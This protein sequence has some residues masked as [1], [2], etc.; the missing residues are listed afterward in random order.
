MIISGCGTAVT[1]TRTGSTY[2]VKSSYNSNADANYH[3]ILGKVY[4]FDGKYDDAER[5]F[6]EAVRLNPFVT[7]IRV[8]LAVILLKTGKI[9]EAK[10]ALRQVA[11]TEEYAPQLHAILGKIYYA[12]KEYDNAV[13]E[14]EKSIQEN[15]DDADV[16]LDLGTVYA[17]INEYVKARETLESLLKVIPDFFLA[18]YY[19]AKIEIAR[20]NLDEGIKYYN[21]SLQNNPDFLGAWLELGEL[22]EK[23]DM[24]NEAITA[25]NKALDLMPQNINI[26]EKIGYLYTKNDNAKAAIK[27]FKEALSIDSTNLDLHLKLG[28]IYFS[29]K[30]YARAIDEFNYILVSI[31]DSPVALYYLGMTYIEKG[32]YSKGRAELLKMPSDTKLYTDSIIWV[33]FS[34]QKENNLKDA[35]DYLKSKISDGVKSV[36]LYKVTASYLTDAKLFDEAIEFANQGLKDFH[37]SETLYFQLGIIYDE[38]GKP[39]IAEEKMQKVIDINPDNPLALNYIGYTWAEK[40]INIDKAEQMIKKALGLRPNDGFIVDSLGWIY[41][42]KGRYKDAMKELQRALKL[43]GDDPIIFEHIGDTYFKLGKPEKAVELYTHALTMKMKDKDFV[44]IKD[45][46]GILKKNAH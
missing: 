23:T 35:I 18:Y 3:F 22:Y 2:P 1:A 10:E 44:R 36:E 28:I 11:D 26:H 39:D 40:A 8:E 24:I 20:N 30:D 27:Y 31:P 45:K 33:A 12:S 4:Y 15:P 6:R 19:I 42:Q 41:Y 7:D 13:K 9:A 25:Y 17:E 16:Y 5:E 21:L 14:F 43:A 37:D 38:Y 34:Y 46:L 32:E 29:E